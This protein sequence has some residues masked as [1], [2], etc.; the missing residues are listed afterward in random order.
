MSSN[1]ICCENNKYPQ[2]KLDY[3]QLEHAKV[4]LLGEGN[5]SFAAGLARKHKTDKLNCS[6]ILATSFDSEKEVYQKYKEAKIFI[7]TFKSLGGKVMY[8]V[9]ARDIQASLPGQQSCFDCI[10][11]NFPHNG[12]KYTGKK[13]VQQKWNNEHRLLISQFLLSAKPLLKNGGEI[14][15]STFHCG[16]KFTQNG[17]DNGC[18]VEKAGRNAGLIHVSHEPFIPPLGYSIVDTTVGSTNSNIIKMMK[19]I[20]NRKT[21]HT[22]FVKKGTW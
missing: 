20:A 10:I 11:F 17:Q 8:N 5:F 19:R 13:S 3:S 22:I 6:N 9:D 18:G 16:G 12:T 14:H 15:L 7:N 2:C 4:L 21:T 1:S